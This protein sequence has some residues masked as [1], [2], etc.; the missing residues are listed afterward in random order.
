MFDRQTVLTATAS[1]VLG[2]GLVLAICANASAADPITIALL[3]PQLISPVTPLIQ[4]RCPSH[5]VAYCRRGLRDC[6][7]INGR[8]CHEAFQHCIEECHCI[9]Q[10]SGEGC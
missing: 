1:M 3:R 5:E 10:T 7:H 4:A 8:G 9:H 6:L 2:A